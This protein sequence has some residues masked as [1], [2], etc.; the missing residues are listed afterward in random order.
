MPSTSSH[1]AP[2]PVQ[3]RELVQLQRQIEVIAPRLQDFDPLRAHLI[4]AWRECLSV[5]SLSSRDS[6]F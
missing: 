4:L 2:T 6:R 3:P 1:D 5:Q